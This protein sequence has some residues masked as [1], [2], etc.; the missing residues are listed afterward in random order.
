MLLRKKK[1]QWYGTQYVQDSTGKSV[2]YTVDETAVTDAERIEMAV[3]TL[4]EAK[5][6][7]GSFDSAK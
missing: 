6:R 4:A 5:K 3:P 2:L 7:A 1:P